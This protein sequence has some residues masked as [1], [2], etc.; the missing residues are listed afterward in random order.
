MTASPQSNFFCTSRSVAL[1]STKY[2]AS[3]LDENILK[4]RKV[5][6]RPYQ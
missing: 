5:Y 3:I 6:L 4:F 2:I 1:A